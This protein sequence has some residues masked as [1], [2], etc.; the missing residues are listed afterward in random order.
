MGFWALG[1]A[2]SSFSLIFVSDF[3]ELFDRKPTSLILDFVRLPFV[4]FGDFGIGEVWDYG[5]LG[6]WDPK[7]FSWILGFWVFGISGF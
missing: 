2:F 4:G 3:L 7:F 1:Q 5:I 6:L